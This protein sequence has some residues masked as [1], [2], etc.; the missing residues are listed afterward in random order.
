M[1]PTPWSKALGVNPRT[2]D[3]LE[4]SGVTEAIL[5]EGLPIKQVQITNDGRAVATIPLEYAAI[6]AGHAMTVL[7]QARTETL[8]G[9]A[10][11]R[12][13]VHVERGVRLLTLTQDETEV[14]ADVVHP[15]GSAE[16]VRTPLLLGADGAQ[17]AVRKALGID[18][19]GDSFPETWTLADLELNG[20][21]PGAIHLNFGA[22]GP[23]VAIPIAKQRW[24]LI[25]MGRDI[26]ARLP[27]HVVG[28]RGRLAV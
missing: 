28:R 27:P 13:G 18:F 9:E 2:L 8:L 17:S 25:A 16:T 19:A 1:E 26:L 22:D 5:A 12:R 11:A 3:M 6:G 7:P 15:D 20:L 4:A 10:L 21:G 23:F 14:R 24:R